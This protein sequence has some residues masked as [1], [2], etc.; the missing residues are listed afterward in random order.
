MFSTWQDVWNNEDLTKKAASNK[1][2]LDKA[3]NIAYILIYDG[4]QH[5]LASMVHIFFDKKKHQVEQSKMKLCLIK[6]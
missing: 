3:N 2:L 1:I 6:N 5:E 4:H